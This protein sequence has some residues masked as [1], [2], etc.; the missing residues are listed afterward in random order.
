[1]STDYSDFITINKTIMDSIW[2]SLYSIGVPQLPLT[3]GE[4]AI[5][6]F[7]AAVTFGV[8]GYILKTRFGSPGTPSRSSDVVPKSGDMGSWAR[9]ALR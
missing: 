4:F 9:Y 5:L 1:M 2:K 7:A 8:L 6:L 3:F